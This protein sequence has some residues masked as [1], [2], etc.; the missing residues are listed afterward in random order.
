VN[1]LFI[2]RGGE[3]TGLGHFARSQRLVETAK[4]RGHEA[5][6]FCVLD[7]PG[8][9]AVEGARAVTDE[10]ELLRVLA[11]RSVD[12]VIIVDMLEVKG[13]V[14]QALER[15]SVPV[16][17]LSPVT[18]DAVWPSLV[19]LRA[20]P[21]QREPRVPHRVGVEFAVLG[22]SVAPISED[23]FSRGLDSSVRRIAVCFGGADP[24]N[25]TLA[26]VRALADHID[27]EL[28]VFVGPAYSHETAALQLGAGAKAMALRVHRGDARLWD[29]LAQS[30][31][32]I[33]GGGL[34]AYESAYG[35]MPAV[36]FVPRGL[37]HEMLH[38]LE[39]AGAIRLVDRDAEHPYQRL[40]EV[41]AALRP[42]DLAA[43]RRA[44]L[45]MQLGD[46]HV[47]CMAAIESLLS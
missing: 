27:A 18:P 31:V 6:L 44:G 29:R 3:R 21:S 2:A 10:A 12:D 38:P 13:G 19:I 15:S 43:M 7:G 26:T 5:E 25:E 23:A 41:V 34:L 32:L 45:S 36:H 11:G 14:A 28:D 20:A 16:V 46:G 9:Q 24:S 47:Q 8:S 4:R 40:V 22:P 1:V 17:S 37:R 39:Q 30:S 42:E 35:G 33:A